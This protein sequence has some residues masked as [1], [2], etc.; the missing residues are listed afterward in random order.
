LIRPSSAVRVYL[1]GGG[2]M[3]AD[4]CGLVCEL[5]AIWIY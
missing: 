1:G 2:I 4:L 3:F 5:D